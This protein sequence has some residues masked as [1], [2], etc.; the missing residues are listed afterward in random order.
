M[1][2]VFYLPKLE[3]PE[4]VPEADHWRLE[5]NSIVPPKTA[6]SITIYQQSI[7]PLAIPPA[8]RSIPRNSTVVLV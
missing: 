2:E 8:R 1:N 5:F 7:I 6:N 3:T 4:S